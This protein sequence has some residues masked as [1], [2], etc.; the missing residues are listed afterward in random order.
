MSDSPAYGKKTPES[1]SGFHEAALEVPPQIHFSI[2]FL[3]GLGYLLPLAVREGY[4]TVN[5]LAFWFGWESVL[6]WSMSTLGFWVGSIP[7]IATLF[8][9]RL[10]PAVGFWG[11]AGLVSRACPGPTSAWVWAHSQA[12]L[13]FELTMCL[14][15]APLFLLSV[16]AVGSSYC[17][18]IFVMLLILYLLF[19]ASAWFAVPWMQAWVALEGGSA[20]PPWTWRFFRRRARA[21]GVG[22][23]RAGRESLR[24]GP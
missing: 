13:D 7:G 8:G 22:R 16:L 21:Q 4:F 5:F 14:R 1:D 6:A 24:D 17:A 18:A 23:H 3:V 9:C 2:R 20:E 10:V 15:G 19:V 11:A 12:C